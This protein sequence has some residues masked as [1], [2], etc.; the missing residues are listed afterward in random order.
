MVGPAV[1]ADKEVGH[2]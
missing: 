1:L 2:D